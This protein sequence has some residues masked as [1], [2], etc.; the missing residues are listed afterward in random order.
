MARYRTGRPPAPR[1]DLS[2]SVP[3]YAL[4][5]FAAWT[6]FVLMVTV[7]VYRWSMILTGRASVAEWRADQPQGAAWYQR[8]MRAHANCIENLPVFAAIVLAAHAADVVDSRLDLL[9]VTVLAA[10]ICQTTVHVSFEQTNA[11]VSVRFS[12]FLVQVLAMIAM[13]VL[14]VAHRANPVA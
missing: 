2:V 6:L 1:G 10:R 12:F 4:L 14:V 9:A 13:I 3:I 8:G 11:V 5:G 7:G